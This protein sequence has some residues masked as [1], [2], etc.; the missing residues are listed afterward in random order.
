MEQ[1]S[2]PFLSS[3]CRTVVT[4]I[5]PQPHS[6]GCP[7]QS[8]AEFSHGLLDFCA[9]VT[10]RS[11]SNDAAPRPPGDQSPHST[12]GSRAGRCAWAI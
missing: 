6:P 3:N 4:W 9:I 5:L 1:V 8:A 10:D 12:V 7:P 2:R 11:G